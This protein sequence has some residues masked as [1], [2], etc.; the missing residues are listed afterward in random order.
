MLDE[1]LGSLDRE[2]RDRL[3]FELR[4]LLATA[5]ITAI[6]VTHDQA[7]AFALADRLAVLHGG[8]IL[9]EGR[10]DE[11]WA[12]PASEVVARFLGLS[13][14]ADATVAEPE[15]SI[16]TTP[17]GRLPIGRPLPG[18]SYRIA[19]RPERL[20]LRAGGPIRG[21]VVSHTFR[22]D[23][24]VLRIDAGGPPLHMAASHPAADGA[25]VELDV[26][27]G[28]VIVLGPAISA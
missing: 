27:Q 18:G 14:L 23:H 20:R 9:Q 2:L 24:V 25:S 10:P 6:Y 22:G 7:E 28:G 21:T 3:M 12:R 15:G 16:A 1:P 11:V 19:V 8:R 4:E 13:N 26:D 5:G 17:W